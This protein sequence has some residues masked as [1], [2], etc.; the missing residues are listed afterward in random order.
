MIVVVWEDPNYT[1]SLET[2]KFGIVFIH[3]EVSKYSPS[4]KRR[5][6]KTQEILWARLKTKGYSILLAS[7]KPEELKKV[8]FFEMFGFENT[9]IKVEDGNIIFRMTL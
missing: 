9:G 4:V 8:K 7:C 6:E 1:V 3:L 5:I 2:N